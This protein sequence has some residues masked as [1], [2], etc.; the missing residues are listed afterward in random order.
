M[1]TKR[2]AWMSQ[3]SETGKKVI[4]GPDPHQHQQAKHSHT[5]PPTQPNAAFKKKIPENT[6]GEE[7]NATFPVQREWHQDNAVPLYSEKKEVQRM[8]AMEKLANDLTGRDFYTN[9]SLIEAQQLN[10]LRNKIRKDATEY[11]RSGRSSVASNLRPDS[12]L[13]RA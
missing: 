13:D 1:T 4:N 8:Q 7:R 5:V 3:R 6:D 10:N 2:D 11:A 9:R 12:S